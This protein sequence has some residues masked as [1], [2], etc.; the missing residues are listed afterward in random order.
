MA[1]EPLADFIE[2]LLTKY[3]N[4]GT[5]ATDPSNVVIGESRYGLANKPDSAFPRLEL[6]ISK[7]KYDGFIDQ[8]IVN[9][10]FRISVAGHIRRDTDDTTSEDMYQAI[11][12]G[13]EMVRLL[14]TF[15]T[16]K[17]AG[18][19]PCDGFI[20]IGGFPEVFFEY[21]LF[22]KVTSVILMAEAEVQLTD[23]FTN[24]P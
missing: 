14:Y 24:N 3:K 6:L 11:Q 19:S 5:F 16:D 22:P 1:R 21:E 2:N 4:E 8:R 18:T 7:L 20:Q 13:R 15:H 23:I 17:I 10:S 9:Q 12:W